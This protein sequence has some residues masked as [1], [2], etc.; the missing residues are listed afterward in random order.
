MDNTRAVIGDGGQGGSR[1]PKGM[2]VATAVVVLVAGVTLAYAAAGP[3]TSGTAARDASNASGKDDA[4]HVGKGRPAETVSPGSGGVTSTA[5]DPS[6][7]AEGACEAFTP[8]GGGTRGET[9]FLDAGHGGIDPG[10]IGQ[11]ESGAEV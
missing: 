2:I 11:A 3:G 10:G 9:V 8:S 1:R 4:R 7:F 5:L 6:Y